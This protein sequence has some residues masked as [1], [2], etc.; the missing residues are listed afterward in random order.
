MVEELLDRKFHRFIERKV[1]HFS[2][3]KLNEQDFINFNTKSALKELKEVV[4]WN[5]HEKVFIIDRTTFLQG[6][7]S[8]IIGLQK[9]VLKQLVN[10]K[11]LRRDCDY[12]WRFVTEYYLSFFMIITLSRLNGE[13]STFIYKDEAEKISDIASAYMGEALR[14]NEGQYIVK[15]LNIDYDRDEVKIELRYN[16]DTHATA[17]EIFKRF[18]KQY[19]ALSGKIDTIEDNAIATLQDFFEE[20]SN[21]LSTTRN[22]LNYKY[23]RGFDDKHFINLYENLNWDNN[24]ELMVSELLKL[25]RPTNIEDSV[26]SIVIINS[27]LFYLL[28]NIYGEFDKRMEFISD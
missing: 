12:T 9:R 23:A 16:K 13:Y 25:K 15:V 5:K 1:E 6:V 26:K 4:C 17:W 20:R 2:S 24:E 14:L 11:S 7:S 22:D 21:I 27:I 18:L 10:L 28:Q 8:E 3:L 19:R